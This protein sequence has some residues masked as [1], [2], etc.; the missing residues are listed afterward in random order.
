MQDGCSHD[1]QVQVPQRLSLRN[2][3]TRS[4]DV[5]INLLIVG[6]DAYKAVA[7]V[8]APYLQAKTFCIQIH[9]VV[10]SYGI[11]TIFLRIVFRT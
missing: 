7:Q 8:L 6:C 2:G 11:E 3:E 4:I 9:L 5:S 1:N 10:K